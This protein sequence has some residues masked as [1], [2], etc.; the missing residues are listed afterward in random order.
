MW[1]TESERLVLKNPLSVIGLL[2]SRVRRHSFQCE[3]RQIVYIYKCI[4]FF[5]SLLF[6]EVWS[7]RFDWFED[8]SS[9]Y[10]LHR[11]HPHHDVEKEWTPDLPA[12]G[13]LDYL[14]DVIC[15]KTCRHTDTQ[16]ELRLRTHLL[17]RLFVALADGSAHVFIVE[18]VFYF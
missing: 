14:R 3:C 15:L 5:W 4:Q 2:T 16:T 10:I 18:G 6:F 17:I 7:L 11:T 12:V 8:S 9:G 1:M 13:S